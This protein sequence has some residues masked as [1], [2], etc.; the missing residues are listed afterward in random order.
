MEKSSRL[1]YQLDMV[2]PSFF[3]GCIQLVLRCNNNSVAC[4]K[5]TT[6]STMHI[7]LQSRG[8]PSR[9]F[10][11]AVKSQYPVQAVIVFK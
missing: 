7:D 2:N 3:N 1:C 11:F 10:S 5:L 9:E 4:N 8:L 6:T